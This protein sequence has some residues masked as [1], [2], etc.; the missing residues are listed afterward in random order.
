[1]VV[2]PTA[3][4][5]S[6][7]LILQGFARQKVQK[8]WCIFTVLCYLSLSLLLYASTVHFQANHEKTCFL[9]VKTEIL[10]SC[11]V[12]M[13]L[14]RAFDFATYQVQSLYCLNMDLMN[15]LLA[16]TSFL[17]CTAQFVSDLIGNP[18]DTFS[19]DTAHFFLQNHIWNIQNWLIW[20]PSKSPDLRPGQFKITIQYKNICIHYYL[21]FC[22]P[23]FIN[24][25]DS[26]Q[27]QVL[28]I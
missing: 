12:N 21:F 7:E 13:Q 16:V 5:C 17:G 18:E 14:I 9:C 23:T 25:L 26:G 15:P 3:F 6:C 2:L 10:F 8:E 27:D 28:I 24:M 1:M 19:H 22:M 20:P 4:R 11:T